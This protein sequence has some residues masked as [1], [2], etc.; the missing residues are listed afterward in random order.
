M[1]KEY[2]LTVNETIYNIVL[3]TLGAGSGMP[4]RKSPQSVTAMPPKKAAEPVQT[5]VL[6]NTSG[7]GSGEQV[8]VPLPGNV[9]KVMV[10]NGD[11]VKK[12]TVLIILEAMKMENEIQASCDGT[13]CNLSVSEGQSID[14]G[15]LICEIR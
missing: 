14:T 10:K 1:K 12:G 8:R 7:S 2:R 6:Q 15:T 5:P 3:E 13:V 11:T 4:P 9:W